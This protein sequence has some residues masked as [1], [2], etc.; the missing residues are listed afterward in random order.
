MRKIARNPE[1]V[2]VENP[3]MPFPLF[4]E[5][6]TMKR[7]KHRKH[8]KAAYNR[9][10]RG[11]YNRRK[12]GSRKSAY[13]RKKCSCRRKVSRR[14]KHSKKLRCHRRRRVGAY[15]K[16]TKSMWK[17]HRAEYKSIGIKRAAKTIA[18]AWKR[19]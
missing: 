12:R 2:V 10:R 9:K 7:R 17:K 1:V 14:R 18:K 19:K 16:F 15:A 5:K 4:G 3:A 13:R 8:R 11:A 6:K